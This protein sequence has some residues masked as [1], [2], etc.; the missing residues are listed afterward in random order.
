MSSVNSVTLVAENEV[1]LVSIAWTDPRGITTLSTLGPALVTLS[2]VSGRAW[3]TGSGPTLSLFFR[4]YSQLLD[5]LPQYTMG[6]KSSLEG[7]V[8]R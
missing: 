3:D 7:K 4:Q 5:G 2:F 1:Q 8:V 6:D